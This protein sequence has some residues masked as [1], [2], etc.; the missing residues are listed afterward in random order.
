[1]SADAPTFDLRTYLDGE[2]ARV[3][4]AL[5]RALERWRGALPPPV[6]DA[7]RYGVLGGGK[8]LR[9]ILCV[10]AYR[11]CGG[12]GPDVRA[13]ELGA[14]LELVHAYSLMHDDLPCMD[15]AELRRGR[16][17]THR[18]HG[19][20]AA[21]RGG[22]ALIPMAVA[23]AFEAARGLGCPPDRARAVAR[24]LCGAAGAGGMV[25]GQALDL[26]AEGTRPGEEALERLHGLK[27]G[28]LLA[29]SLSMGALAADAQ[30]EVRRGL[31]AYGR[32]IGLAFQIADDILDA[33]ATAGELGKNPS[34]RV[35]DKSTYV[36]MHGLDGAR[37]RARTKVQE[38]RSAL[39]RTG[40]DAPALH[41]LARYVVERRR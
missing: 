4:E 40:V 19:E 30:E 22:A 9:P 13:H 34:D 18:V 41:A 37:T 25:G 27:T 12:T 16:A 26:L 6:R 39:D 10:T 8:R 36:A 17:T 24:L 15:D 21:T 5:E 7:V 38:A 35:H 14:S 33:T 1:M 28:A 31:D 2:R 32:A 11:V 3:E 23:T 29:A 20:W